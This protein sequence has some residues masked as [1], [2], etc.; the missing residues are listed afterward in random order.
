MASS[1]DHPAVPEKNHKVEGIFSGTLSFIFNTWKW[2]ALRVN[3]LFCSLG[4]FFL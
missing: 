1:V 4:Y 2:V 3:I